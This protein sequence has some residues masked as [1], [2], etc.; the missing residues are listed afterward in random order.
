MKS[1]WK[2][3]L[4]ITDHQTLALPKG[5]QVL[6]AQAQNNVPCLWVLV[7]VDQEAESRTFHIVGTGHPADHVCELPHLGT[8]QIHKGA[9]VFHVFGTKE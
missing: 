5:A 7:D 9:L 1:I 4:A 3:E 8:F 2:Y 6:T